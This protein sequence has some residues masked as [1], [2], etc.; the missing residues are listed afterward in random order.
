M[1]TCSVTEVVK[2][3]IL[4]S[5]IRLRVCGFVLAYGVAARDHVVQAPHQEQ[6]VLDN[7]LLMSPLHHSHRH[8]HRHLKLFTRQQVFPHPARSPL[9]SRSLNLRIII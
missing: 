2:T 1:K 3:G 5:V 8:R 9:F 6:K 4:S 7:L